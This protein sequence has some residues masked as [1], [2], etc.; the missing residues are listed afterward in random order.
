MRKPSAKAVRKAVEILEAYGRSSF[1]V[2]EGVSQGTTV[3]HALM[4]VLE[5]HGIADAAAEM[6]E[7]GNF[8]VTAAIVRCLHDGKGKFK[9]KGNRVSITL[10]EFWKQ[11]E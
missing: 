4:A 1:N 3:G 5:G 8:H 10:P 11:V 7:E 9:R 6:F 2:P